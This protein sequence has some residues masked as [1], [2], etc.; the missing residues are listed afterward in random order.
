MNDTTVAMAVIVGLT[1]RLLIPILI[2]ILMVT[3]LVR[4]D[5]RWRA[6][7]TR[8]PAQV[9]KPECWRNRRCSMDQRRACSAFNSVLPCWQVFRRSDGYL[10]QKCLTCAVFASAPIPTRA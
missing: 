7:A 8:P 2:T 9:E 6:D 3:T 5:R 4:L 1:V 10:Q